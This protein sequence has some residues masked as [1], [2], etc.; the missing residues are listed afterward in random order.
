MVVADGRSPR[1]GRF[2]ENIGSYDPGPDPSHI[3][4]NGPRALEWIGKGA[5][6]TQA[7]TRLM[8]VAGVIARQEP[9]ASRAQAGG[10]R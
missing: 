3:E 2:I 9:K 5:Q 1:D 8:E 7:V 6:P 4:I 10:S